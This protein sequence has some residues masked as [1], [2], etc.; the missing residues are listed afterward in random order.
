MSL[1]IDPEDVLK[2]LLADGWHEVVPGTFTLDAYEFV[3]HGQDGE[4]DFVLHGG[5]DSGVC[6]IGF[7]FEQPASAHF[8]LGPLT[9]ILAV[10]MTS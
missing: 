9:A 3:E 2:V 4:R 6:S 1:E 5:G 7:R 10:K 8:I